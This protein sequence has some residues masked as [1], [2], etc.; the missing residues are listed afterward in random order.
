M[1]STGRTPM[2]SPIRLDTRM[3]E[4]Q[5]LIGNGKRYLVPPCQSGYAWLQEQWKNLRNDI[6]ELQSQSFCAIVYSAPIGNSEPTNI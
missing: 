2:S 1:R 6:L 3:I 4:Y 5:E